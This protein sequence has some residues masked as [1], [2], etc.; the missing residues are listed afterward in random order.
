MDKSL[1]APLCLILLTKCL[2]WQS[3]LNSCFAQLTDFFCP[4]STSF[5]CFWIGRQYLDQRPEHLNPELFCVLP[6]IKNNCVRKFQFNSTTQTLTNMTMQMQLNAN[7]GMQQIVKFLHLPSI[8]E[9]CKQ[10][11]ATSPL[12]RKNQMKVVDALCSWEWDGCVCDTWNL[13][14]WK[15][16]SYIWYNGKNYSFIHQSTVDFPLLPITWSAEY[17]LDGPLVK[18]ALC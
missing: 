3:I 14:N 4:Q 12:K 6:F 7:L 2:Y 16:I 1:V 13:N 11:D 18:R 10:I 5:A 15:V 9:I 8:I 17:T